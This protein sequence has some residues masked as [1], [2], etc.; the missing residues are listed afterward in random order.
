M[1]W[2]IQQLREA[3][4]F[5]QQPSYLFRDNDGIYGD[6]VSRFLVGTGI[7]EVKTAHRCPWQIHSWKGMEAPYGESCWIT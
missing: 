3:M 4:P 1:D 2:V 5:G 6:E 7:A